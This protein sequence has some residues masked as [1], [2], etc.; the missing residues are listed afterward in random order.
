[1]RGSE[2]IF[3]K[4]DSGGMLGILLAMTAMLVALFQDDG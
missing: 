2:T 1:V 4:D 3:N